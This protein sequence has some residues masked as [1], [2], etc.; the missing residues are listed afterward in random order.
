MIRNTTHASR[1]ISNV[2]LVQYEWMPWK[3]SQ[4][5]ALRM[6]QSS[7]GGICW[8]RP[9]SWF[10]SWKSC[11]RP[12]CRLQCASSAWLIGCACGFRNHPSNSYVHPSILHVEFLER[13]W[14][15]DP[16]IGQRRGESSLTLGACLTHFGCSINRLWQPCIVKIVEG[17]IRTSVP[18]IIDLPLLAW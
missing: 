5:M 14:Q 18:S 13:R 6:E 2:H 9:I 10:C 11:L 7:V 15:R 16:I 17:P 1:D 3:V 12:A 4:R 8:R